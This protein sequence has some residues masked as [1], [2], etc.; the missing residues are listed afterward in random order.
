MKYDDLRSKILNLIVESMFL[1]FAVLLVFF[2][3]YE[4]FCSDVFQAA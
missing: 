3:G 2:S 1:V 4:F